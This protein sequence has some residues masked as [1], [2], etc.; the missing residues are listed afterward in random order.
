[1][2]RVW[3]CIYIWIA[4]YIGCSWSIYWITT[5]IPYTSGGTCMEVSSKARNWILLNAF[6]PV[7][8]ALDTAVSSHYRYIPLSHIRTLISPTKFS[9][10]VCSLVSAD[11]VLHETQRDTDLV[12]LFCWLSQDYPRLRLKF[13]RSE[14]YLRWLLI[15]I[16]I[17]HS[18][19]TRSPLFSLYISPFPFV[20]LNKGL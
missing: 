16:N 15:Y 18:S 19:T 13:T 11:T 9:Y 20:A 8:S 5:I 3:G 1:M 14:Y 10:T 2:S 4:S 17:V 12:G 7:V 6:Y